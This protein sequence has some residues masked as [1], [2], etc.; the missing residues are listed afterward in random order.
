LHN[1]IRILWLLVGLTVTVHA[2]VGQASID[3]SRL[4]SR[5]DTFDILIQSRFEAELQ[6]F[7]A[8]LVESLRRTRNDRGGSLTHIQTTLQY[9]ERGKLY[10]SIADTTQMHAASLRL[11]RKHFIFTLAPRRTIVDKTAVADDDSITMDAL[12]DAGEKQNRPA[13]R[14]RGRPVGSPYLALR[15]IQL[16]GIGP[17]SFTSIKFSSD[18]IEVVRVDSVVRRLFGTRVVWELF[19]SV[20]GENTAT[21]TVDSASRDLM[22]ITTERLDG[23]FTSVAVNRRYRRVLSGLSG[24]AAN[25][26][27][28]H[29]SAAAATDRQSTSRPAWTSSTFSRAFR[30][31]H[32]YL[33]SGASR[34]IRVR[35]ARATFGIGC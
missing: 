31:R 6:K 8:T 12:Y 9:D 14:I 19:A 2:Q 4:T 21:L 7:S 26:T 10:L 33:T 15:S 34:S 1:A 23:T 30:C 25:A 35:S 27:S 17:T 29:V 28:D 32:Q 18:D 11:Q 22:R 20:D 3:G 13:R 16:P 5:S 24:R